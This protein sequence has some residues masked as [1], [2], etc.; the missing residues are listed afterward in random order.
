MP[1]LLAPLAAAVALGGCDSYDSTAKL[2]EPISARTLPPK[3]ETYEPPVAPS[4]P[5]DRPYTPLGRMSI[6][7]TNTR[8]WLVGALQWNARRVGAD[9]VVVE[10]SRTE[11]QYDTRWTE[12]G[13][14]WSGGVYYGRGNRRIY[15][16]YG[17]GV[18]WGYSSGYSETVVRLR[19]TVQ[20]TFVELLDKD[21]YGWL[22]FV[23]I[24]LGNRE[25]ALAVDYVEPGGPADE[26]GLRQGD[27]LVRVGSYRA[28]QGL[29]DY[30]ANAP[31]T[32][33]GRPVEVEVERGGEARVFTVAPRRPEYE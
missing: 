12:Y 20:A 15:P 13:P 21:T 4:V 26:A 19:R 16:D 17:F 2:Y 14:Y 7:T 11:E 3:P 22:G 31:A 29:G 32:E 9:M 8:D 27:V 30:Y 28:D 25:G 24:E 18:G 10:S 5:F 33:A 23:P 6:S 1:V